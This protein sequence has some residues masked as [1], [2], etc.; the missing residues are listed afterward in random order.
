MRLY[1]IRHGESDGN[2]TKSFL[3]D[4]QGGLTKKGIGQAE[5]LAKRFRK[6]PIDVILSS[7]LKRATDTAK[8]I[9]RAT[10]KKI[11][12]TKLIR[13]ARYP[14][15]YK[16]RRD[17]DP[18]IVRIRALR[19]KHVNDRKWHYSDEEN[20][21]DL[22]ARIEKFLRFISKR[23]GK[24]VLAVGH[25]ITNRMIIALMMFGEALTP[26]IFEGFRRGLVTINTGITVCEMEGGEWKVLTWNDHAHLG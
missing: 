6:I 8:I 17:G 18:E 16:G 11:V 14:K 22:K 23:K 7:D 13:E 9:R 20:F 15:E 24:N 3:P 21:F 12:I 1:I 19:R 5:K 25:G 26:Q 2:A 4:H 10:R